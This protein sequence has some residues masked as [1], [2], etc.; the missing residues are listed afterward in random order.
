MPPTVNELGQP[1]GAALPGWA[2]PPLPPRVPMEGQWCRL[3]PLDAAR[4]AADLYAANAADVEGRSWTY[5][6]YGP[7]PTLA[8]YRAWMEAQCCSDDPLFFTIIDKTDSKPAGVASYLRIA[9][10][11]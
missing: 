3:V 6:A 9:P 10:A 4:H 2:P 11:S 8:S 7:F 5:L 1:I